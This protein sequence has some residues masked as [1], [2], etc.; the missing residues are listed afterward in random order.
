MANSAV[1]LNNESFADWV[2]V[3]VLPVCVVFGA[4]WC[5]PAGELRQILTALAAKY[6]NKVRFAN[7]DVTKSKEVAD[8]HGVDG[9]PTVMMF[10]RGKKVK[11]LRGA[12]AMKN[13]QSGL[14]R[15]IN[16]ALKS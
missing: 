11:E 6:A 1:F 12:H 13:V 8:R 7:V 14:T 9:V 4:D 2:E 3:P 5:K 10:V 16:S 15:F